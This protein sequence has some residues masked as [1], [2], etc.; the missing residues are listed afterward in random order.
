MTAPTATKVTTAPVPRHIIGDEANPL[1]VAGDHRQHLARCR[2]RPAAPVEFPAG[3]QA[4]EKPPGP[5]IEHHGAAM[6][7]HSGHRTGHDD[8]DHCRAPPGHIG[9]IA[10]GHRA[11]DG[12]TDGYRHQRRRAHPGNARQ[13]PHRNPAT[14][15]PLEPDVDPADL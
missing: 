1:G 11:V 6:A 8:G 7:D 12:A 15:D 14:L 13:R 2:E 10:P 9:P 4:F 5:G 3:H